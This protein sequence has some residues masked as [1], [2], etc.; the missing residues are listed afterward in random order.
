MSKG[1]KETKLAFWSH[2][3]LIKLTIVTDSPP[4]AQNMEHT[5]ETVGAAAIFY[6]TGVG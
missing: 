6:N 1:R 2:R 4:I 3:K 5:S